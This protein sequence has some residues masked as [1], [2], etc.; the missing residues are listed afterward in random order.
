MAR[1]YFVNAPRKR[2]VARRKARKV[3]A[4]RR[5]TKRGRDGRFMKSVVDR[6]GHKISRA[7]WR[8]SGYR[9]NP[10]ARRLPTRSKST[11]RFLKR[12]S[13]RND[14]GRSR[15]RRRHNPITAR[16]RR[17]HFRRNPPMFSIKGVINTAIEG[18]A[19]G[20]GVTAGKIATRQGLAL[21]KINPATYTGAA[22]Q[23][24]VGVALALVLRRFL[25][26]GIGRAVADGAVYGAFNGAFESVIRLAAP[27][28]ADKLLGDTYMLPGLAAYAAPPVLTAGV[29]NY[30]VHPALMAA[31]D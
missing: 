6:H 30:N 15:R 3:A 1:P 26:G 21:V 8:R 10:M 9:R 28:V 17:R 5:L 11:G 2:K 16:R 29:G 18:L 20:A 19:G 23:G 4:K 14:P 7:A 12:G 25:R 13:R 22:A 24:A 31:Y 27:T